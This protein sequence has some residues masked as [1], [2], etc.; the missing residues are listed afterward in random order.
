ML[1]VADATQ[2]LPAD[3][4]GDRL[5]I[6]A[7]T[8]LAEIDHHVEVEHGREVGLRRCRSRGGFSTQ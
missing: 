8:T 2:L 4:P 3:G 1:D 5:R 6:R 7:Y